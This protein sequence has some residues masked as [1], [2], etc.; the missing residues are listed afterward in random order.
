MSPVAPLNQSSSPLQQGAQHCKK[1]SNKPYRK[2]SPLDI[3]TTG[4]SS[5]QPCRIE[6]WFHTVDGRL[7]IT[8]SPGRRDWYANLLAQP[9]FTFHLKRS[10]QADL[11][12]LATPV[13]DPAHRRPSFKKSFASAASP[14]TLT[15]G[16]TAAPLV[17]VAFQGA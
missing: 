12:A 10:A 4:R 11:P 8:G 17:E 13:R 1:A 3:T 9:H 15:T 14:Q 7:Y 16:P 2:T 5:G 6:I